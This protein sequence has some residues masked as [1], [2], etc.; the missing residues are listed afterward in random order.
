MGSDTGEEKPGRQI[1]VI[2]V[3]KAGE[4][5]ETGKVA[6]EYEFELQFNADE[7]ATQT[8]RN[9]LAEFE[10]HAGDIIQQWLAKNVD[11]YRPGYVKVIP[12]ID[13]PTSNHEGL[14]LPNLTIV[15][16]FLDQDFNPNQPCVYDMIEGGRLILARE[17]AT[18]L[19]TK[20]PGISTPCFISGTASEIDMWQQH[21][22]QSKPTQPSKP[23]NAR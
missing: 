5:V 8:I 3:T 7:N 6:P 11:G 22:G 21:I 17:I 16:Q 10:K 19:N 14:A 15:I 2:K 13:N 9:N 23:N 12:T 20:Y 4:K 1:E 18:R